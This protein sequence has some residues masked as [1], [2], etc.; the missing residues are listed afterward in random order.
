MDPNKKN[1]V[2]ALPLPGRLPTEGAIRSWRQNTI[3][4]EPEFWE[5]EYQCHRY[6][7]NLS[8]EELV[9]RHQAI[10]KNMEHLLS[11]ER[12]V[13]PSVS[14]LSSWYWFRKEH[15]TRYEFFLRGAKSPVQSPNLYA[16]D[17]QSSQPPIRPR[18]PNAGDI[19]YRFGSFKYLMPDLEAGLIRISPASSYADSALDSARKDEEKEKSS[20]MAGQYTK[21]TTLDGQTIP[22]IGDVKKTVSTQDYYLLSMA[23][24]YDELLFSDFRSDGYMVVK[25][26][27][28]LAERIEVG[29][30]EQL[31]GWVF[32]H[33][34]VEYFDPYEVPLGH[35]HDP[36]MT[37][38]FSYAYQREYRFIWLS[39]NGEK[40]GGHLKI[41]VV[42]LRDI[43]EVL[44]L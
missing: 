27:D 12:D 24:D 9:A 29:S 18:H 34:P 33:N 7:Q 10:V 28:A 25:D 43:A 39:E 14:F 42:N 22:I 3:Y 6:L 40:A 20:Y 30:Q 26:P 13:I 15:Q 11:A 1:H 32:H 8:V 31:P 36:L 5:F 19:L 4:Y 17:R 23:A 37:K 2:P 38:D 16:F 44:Q 21:I 41:P 35:S